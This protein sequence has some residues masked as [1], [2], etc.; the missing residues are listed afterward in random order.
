MR[1]RLLALAL[2]L[3]GLPA[4]ADEPLSPGRHATLEAPEVRKLIARVA[5]QWPALGARLRGLGVELLVPNARAGAD[6]DERAIHACLSPD[7][8]T[9]LALLQLDAP[10]PERRRARRAGLRRRARR[11]RP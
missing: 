5:K 9:L 7:G 11:Q 10:K 6:A 3:A 1:A 8:H 4:A 2:M